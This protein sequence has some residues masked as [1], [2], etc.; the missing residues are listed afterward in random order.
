MPGQVISR[1]P[2]RRFQRTGISSVAE[3]MSGWK[4][5]GLTFTL[6]TVIVTGT[7]VLEMNDS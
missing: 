7:G 2:D 3:K 4:A 6:V 5:R 1:L